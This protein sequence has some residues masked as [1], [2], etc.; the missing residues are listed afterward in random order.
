MYRLL[1]PE[2][3]RKT[4]RAARAAAASRAHVIARVV[5]VARMAPARAPVRAV[6]ARGRMVR[7]LI[8]AAVDIPQHR[9]DVH[10]IPIVPRSAI[11]PV[12]QPERKVAV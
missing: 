1:K 4:S 7:G 6:A 11:Q 3:I 10:V 2:P 12:R 5:R 8:H 9:R